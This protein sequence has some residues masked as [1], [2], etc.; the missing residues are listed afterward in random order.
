[1]LFSFGR[2]NDIILHTY[3]TVHLHISDFS[4]SILRNHIVMKTKARE[5]LEKW[6]E[7]T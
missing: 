6:E 4:F 5:V 2:E 1:V 3:N 7:T